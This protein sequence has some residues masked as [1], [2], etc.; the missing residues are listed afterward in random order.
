M[1]HQNEKTQS[2]RSQY[3]QKP[4]RLDKLVP[5]YALERKLG[6]VHIATP[7]DE[8]LTLVNDALEKAEKEDGRWTKRLS[9]QTRKAALW[10]H[11]EHRGEYRWVMGPH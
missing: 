7:D 6:T 5:T 2:L 3:G 4:L 8:V 10:I 11:N 9:E 1:I